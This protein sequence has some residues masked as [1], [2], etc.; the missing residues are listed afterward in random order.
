MSTEVGKIHYTLD[1]D[2]SKFEKGASK[3]SGKLN[4]LAN[5]FKNAQA[6]SMALA[7]GLAVAGAAVGGL[8]VMAVKNAMNLETMTQGFV[9]LLGS[10]EEANKAIKMIVKDAA[11]T[12]FEI[13]GLIKANQLLTAVT[14]DAERSEG[15]LMNVGKALAGMGKGQEE[16]DRIIVNL[17]QIGAV[18]KASM[19]DIKQFAF[20]G[21]PI[22]EML[23]EATGKTGEELQDFITEGGVTFDVLEQMFANAGEGAGRF[24]NAFEVQ[25]GTL[26]QQL[27][28][29][30]DSFFMLSVEIITNS[31]IYDIVK[32]AVATLQENIATFTT[33]MNEAGGAVAYAKLKFEEY[34]PAI[35][36]LAGAL[37]GAL[38]PAFVALGASIWTALAPLLPFIAIGALMGLMINELVEY[39][40]GWDLMIQKVKDTFWELWGIIEPYVMPI[41]EDMKRMIKQELV[42][43]LKEIWAIIGPYVIPVL[44]L[45]GAI[46]GGVV[47]VAIAAVI[48]ILWVIIKLFTLWAERMRDSMNK[49]KDDIQRFKEK[50]EEVK[51]KILGIKD[52]IVDGFNDLK[53]KIS[54]SIDSIK[55]KINGAVEAMKKL[56]PLQRFSPSLVDN[57]KRGTHALVREY[58]GMF[59]DI[60]ALSADT[61]FNLAGATGSVSSITSVN[62][63]Q[64]VSVSVNVDNYYGDQIGLTNFAEKIMKEID[65][66]NLSRSNKLI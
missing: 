21:I 2:D 43:A 62:T 58:E 3:A 63:P 37:V 18:G 27:S 54:G 20:A 66:I 22:F 10:T 13:P 6:S 4:S 29:L 5:G 15:I 32:N 39:F 25:S 51:N 60:N 38:I 50:F 44:K 31:G 23:T 24:A 48:A 35:Y 33:K 26:A 1:L 28:N 53:S 30:K 12:P 45:M 16:L 19:L 14:K 17:Q 49:G 41:I 52:S 47:I 59:A 42:P 34:Q 11:S 46:L 55:E 8:A 7:K 61:R 64:P 40:G 36:V 9:G 56:N 65:T 57:V